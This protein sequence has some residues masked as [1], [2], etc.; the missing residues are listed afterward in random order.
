MKNKWLKKKKDKERGIETTILK[1]EAKKEIEAGRQR[2]RNRPD[3]LREKPK[4]EQRAFLMQRWKIE[5]NIKVRR[6][7]GT[8]LKSVL[9]SLLMVSLFSYFSAWASI[10]KMVAKNIIHRRKASW[11]RR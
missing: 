10:S 11:H 6:A 1:A 2:K 7:D 5:T 4:E 3:R 8:E 9:V